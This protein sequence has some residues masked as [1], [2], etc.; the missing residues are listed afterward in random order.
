V[1][2]LAQVRVFSSAPIAKQAFTS[3]NNLRRY[4]AL[5]G[6][7]LPFQNFNIRGK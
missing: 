7:H 6:V 3:A 1:D 2:L 4:R 5:V